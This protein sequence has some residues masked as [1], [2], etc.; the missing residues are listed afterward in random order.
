LAVLLD[1]MES[2]AFQSDA[3]KIFSIGALGPGIEMETS[4]PTTFTTSRL[5]LY[6]MKAGGFRAN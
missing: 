1:E 6:S 3:T 4:V 5:K 2:P